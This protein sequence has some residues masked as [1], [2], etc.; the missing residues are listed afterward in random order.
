MALKF[1][2]ARDDSIYEAFPDVTLT[3]WAGWFVSS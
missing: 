1:T 2:V 3:P